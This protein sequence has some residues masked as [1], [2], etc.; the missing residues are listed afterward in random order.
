VGAKP[1]QSACC[2]G[3]GEAGPGAGRWSEVRSAGLGAVENPA[4]RRQ[5]SP[6]WGGNEP[7]S[8][9]GARPDV[10]LYRPGK[11]QLRR[12]DFGWNR[13]QRRGRKSL[14]VRAGQPDGSVIGCVGPTSAGHPH[15]NYP[16]FRPAVDGGVVAGGRS[17]PNG[18]AYGRLGV[19]NMVVRWW[20]R[21]AMGKGRAGLGV[22][23]WAAFPARPVSLWLRSRRA[24]AEATERDWPKRLRRSAAHPPATARPSGVGPLRWGRGGPPGGRESFGGGH[25][26]AA[27]PDGNQH[28]ASR[29][30]RS[31]RAARAGGVG[32]ALT[33]GSPRP[34]I[35]RAPAVA[36]RVAAPAASSRQRAWPEHHFVVQ[37]RR[38]ARRG[39]TTGAHAKIVRGPRRAFRATPGVIP[40]APAAPADPPQ[41]GPTQKTGEP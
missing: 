21:G 39:K 20:P 38:S 27:H 34:R 13:L 30:K 37:P 6:W 1:G 41:G 12:K 40:P 25:A 29:G 32:A 11:T 35:H 19:G 5:S 7:D 22:P 14:L 18:E 33:Q 4:A 26:P 17:T 24:G 2:H 3:P 23:R 36:R 15:E 28:G 9:R 31:G 16:G 10:T 8:D